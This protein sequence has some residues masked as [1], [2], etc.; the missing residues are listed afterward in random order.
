MK[1]ASLFL[2]F[3]LLFVASCREDGGG[4]TVAPTFRKVSNAVYKARM[5]YFV[6]NPIPSGRKLV[7][8]DSRVQRW[9]ADV[10]LAGWT[11]RGIDGDTTF[12][13][14]KRVHFHISE[15]PSQVL[16]EVGINDLGTGQSSGIAARFKEI[17]TS[18]Q[19]AGIV[20]SV[21]SILPTQ[22]LDLDKKVDSA[23][24]DLKALCKSLGAK[25]YDETSVFEQN[26]NVNASLYVDSVHF[27]HNGY[28]ALLEQLKRD[29]IQ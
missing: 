20:V 7:I 6:A 8:G 17:I 27:A 29:G 10:F 9:P 28:Q 25:Y 22:D 3:A 18:F 13:V 14:L 4:G 5:E 21:V 11:N 1:K 24:K 2:I 26:Y 23:N 12:G 19:K 16:L 15:K